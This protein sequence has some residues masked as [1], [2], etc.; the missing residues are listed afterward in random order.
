[1]CKKKAPLVAEPFH[2][3]IPLDLSG[4]DS[5]GGA[6]ADGKSCD[7][8]F[9]GQSVYSVSYAYDNLDLDASLLLAARATVHATRARPAGPLVAA[10]ASTAPAVKA[11]STRSIH[12]ST[13]VHHLFTSFHQGR[14]DQPRRV[15]Q[16]HH[17][18]NI[19][20]QA[21]HANE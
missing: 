2:R 3:L 5:C 11:T 9:L 7:A 13:S 12:L 16:R 14:G 15:A 10:T 21:H 1:M 8:L 6:H 17:P 19:G 18:S 20:Y 4:D